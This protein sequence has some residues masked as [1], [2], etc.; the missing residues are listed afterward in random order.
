[1]KVP[2]N[3]PHFFKP[4]LP[5]FKNGLKIPIG[6]LKYLKRH[7]QYEHAIL[8]RKGKKWLVKVNDRRLEKEYLYEDKE[9]EEEEEGTTHDDKSFGQPHFECIVRP[10]CLSKD[11]DEDEYEDKDETTYDKSFGQPHFECIIRQYCLSKGFMV[12][13][14]ITI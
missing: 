10:Y 6:F 9:E 1:M 14:K 13:L 4:I 11:E 7:D 2:P 5:G 8:R 3:K 12:S